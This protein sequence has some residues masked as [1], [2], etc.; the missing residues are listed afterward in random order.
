MLPLL[1]RLRLG[2]RKL[3]LI[4]LDDHRQRNQQLAPRQMLRCAIRGSIREGDHRELGERLPLGLGAQPAVGVERLRPGRKV[5]LGAVDNEGGDVD[6]RLGRDEL[7]RDD[8]ALAGGDL[9]GAAR[10]DGR[11]DAEGFLAVEL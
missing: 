7:A 9:A 4:P 11:L 6:L 2:V 5:G 1:A 3:E 10:R 8:P